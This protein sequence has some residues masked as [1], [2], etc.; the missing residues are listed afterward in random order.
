MKENHP[1]GPELLDYADAWD[2]EVARTI[3]IL[4]ELSREYNKD[5]QC[6]YVRIHTLIERGNE[7]LSL[8]SREGEG[9]GWVSASATS[10]ASRT[11]AKC[12]APGCAMVTARWST[13]SSGRWN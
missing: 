9:G 13:K 7:L 3:S 1:I 2:K 5:E 11:G 6:D 8:T 12:F 10:P 4:R